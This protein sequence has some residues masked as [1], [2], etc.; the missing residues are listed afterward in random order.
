MMDN[1]SRLEDKLLPINQV[2]KKLSC[3]RGHVYNLIEARKLRSVR[4]G[5]HWRVYLSS[6]YKYI[7]DNEFDPESEGAA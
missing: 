2:A 6:V 5:A 1:K 3:S 7:K 4:M